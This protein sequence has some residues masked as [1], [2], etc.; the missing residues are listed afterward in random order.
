LLAFLWYTW[1]GILFSLIPV[2]LDLPTRLGVFPLPFVSRKGLSASTGDAS[3]FEFSPAAPS[4]REFL[5]FSFLS[6]LNLFVS[7]SS[8]GLPL[9]V[10]LRGRDSIFKQSSRVILLLDQFLLGISRSW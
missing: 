2:D 4:L 7:P 10:D 6:L 3:F 1:V 9:S 5:V 8:L